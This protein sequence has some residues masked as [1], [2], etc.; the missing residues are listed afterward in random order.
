ME[1]RTT[2][3]P[4]PSPL[5]ST[6]VEIHPEKYIDT[7]RNSYIASPTKVCANGDNKQ[8]SRRGRSASIV[9]SVNSSETSEPLWEDDP[10]A[11]EEGLKKP[12]VSVTLV[13][14]GYKVLRMQVHLQRMKQRLDGLQR[15]AAEQSRLGLYLQQ[16]TLDTTQSVSDTQ[17]NIRTDDLAESNLKQINSD[18]I[19]WSHSVSPSNSQERCHALTMT[20]NDSRVEQH[21]GEL[22]SGAD[23]VP[24]AIAKLLDKI[25]TLQAQLKETND[26]NEQLQL[27]VRRLEEENARFQTQMQLDLAANSSCN[28]RL[29]DAVDDKENEDHDDE[30]FARLTVAVFAKPSPLQMVIEEDMA[31]LKNHEQCQRKLHELWDIV[32]NLRAFVNAYELERNTMKRQRDDAIAD[33]KRAEAENIQLASSSNPHGKIK[34]LQQVKRDNQALRQKNRA[35]NEMIA[36]M[37]AKINSH[38]DVCSSFDEIDGSPVDTTLGLLTFDGVLPAERGEPDVR[39]CDIIRKIHDRGEVLERRLQSLR[40]ARESV[41]DDMTL[42]GENDMG[43]CVA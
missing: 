22:Q 20:A 23:N 39:S 30:S 26:E 19:S 40:L 14:K 42:V 28:Q 1:T 6:A 17:L 38:M 4:L 35:L 12:V 36:K 34:Y 9:S 25:E 13:K 2:Q 43:N 31:V 5:D 29:N 21:N 8:V 37:A 3:Q 27:T 7:L 11:E 15:I 24:P 16:S 10:E 33:A 18:N 32:R 41:P